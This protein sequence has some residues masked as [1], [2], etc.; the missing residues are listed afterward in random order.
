MNIMYAVEEFF[1]RIRRDA[2]RLKLT[3]WNSMGNKVVS[4]YVSAASLDKVW[5]NVSKASSDEVVNSVKEHLKQ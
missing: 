4:D 5:E 2:E 3:V 1:V